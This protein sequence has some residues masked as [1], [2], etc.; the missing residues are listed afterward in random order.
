MPAAGTCL[1]L[2]LHNLEGKPQ[3]CSPGGKASSKP[4]ACPPHNRGETLSTLRPVGP[5]LRALQ[6]S[7]WVGRALCPRGTDGTGEHTCE[8]HILSIA[9]QQVLRVPGLWGQLWRGWGL[10][11]RHLPGSSVWGVHPWCVA[12]FHLKPGFESQFFEPQGAKASRASQSK[13]A[14]GK[15][16]EKQT[17]LN[18]PSASPGGTFRRLGGR[19]QALGS[20]APGMSLGRRGQ[21]KTCYCS[22][23]RGSPG[24]SG[25]HFLGV[26]I[27][28]ERDLHGLP[29]L[30]S[31]VR[32]RGRVLTLQQLV[33][34][35]CVWL[36]PPVKW[37]AG[38]NTHSL[39]LGPV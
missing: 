33:C 21:R 29:R 10:E 5:S 35:L 15:F 34:G 6:R 25:L 26:Q 28:R 37:A 13:Q 30:S 16:R 4:Q 1:C 23:A 18:F 19:G 8:S 9:A 27:Q 24:G 38:N 2:T 14:F 22:V 17:G 3:L 12:A 31:Q 7:V 11:P 20:L 39:A 32:C 36:F